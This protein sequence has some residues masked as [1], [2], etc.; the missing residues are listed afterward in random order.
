LPRMNNRI[1]A[2][3][4]ED[5]RTLILDAAAQGLV[6]HGYDRVRLRDIAH[7]AGCSIGLIQHYFD[8]R[9][10]LLKQAYAYSSDALVARWRDVV[11]T[12]DDPWRRIVA[13]I[14]QLANDADLREH[15]IRWTEF[16][17]IAAR[18]PQLAAEVQRVY[19]VWQEALAQAIDAGVQSGL[20]TPKLSQPDAIDLLL[21]A[22]DGFE[23]QVAAGITGV[24]QRRV[25]Q[26]LLNT[27]RLILGLPSEH[28]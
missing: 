28:A 18:R 3:V 26:V 8:T 1:G 14:D 10:E 17:V 23:L 24:D 22:V 2:A 15:C 7:Q 9:E 11:L 6:E 5:P 27:A 21:S 12:E 25:R 4:A 20:F 19:D 16:S 13:L